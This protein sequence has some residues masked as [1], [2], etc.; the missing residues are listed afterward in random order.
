MNNNEVIMPIIRPMVPED[1]DLIMPFFDQMSGESRSFLYEGPQRESMDR[2]LRGEYPDRRTFIAVDK[3]ENGKEFAAGY[4]FLWN[5]NTKTPSLGIAVSEV[6]KGR[7]LGRALM[8]YAED[9]CYKHNKGGIFLT[10]HIANARAQK[11]YLNSGYTKLGV[12]NEVVF[13]RY[14]DDELP[15]NDGTV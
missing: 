8:K 4:V 2:C 1:R 9:Y 14:F 11:L 15:E 13:F 7:H 6:W 5:L 12:N 3:D 10:T